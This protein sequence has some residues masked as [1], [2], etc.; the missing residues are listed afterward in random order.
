MPHLLRRSLLSLS[1]S[2]SWDERGRAGVLWARAKTTS[3]GEVPG[4]KSCHLLTEISFY[5]LSRL[6][7]DQFDFT[8]VLKQNSLGTYLGNCQSAVFHFPR[9]VESAHP[10]CQISLLSVVIPP[11]ADPRSKIKLNAGAA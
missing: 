3:W 5:V 2:L 7:Y 9:G 8:E 1:L 11:F 10:E 6:N 4:H